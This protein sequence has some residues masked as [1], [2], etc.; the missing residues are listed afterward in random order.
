MRIYIDNLFQEGL[1]K[2]ITHPR[3]HELASSWAIVG[4]KTD[5][6]ADRARRLH[7]LLEIIEGSVPHEE[8]RYQDWL[9]FARRWSELNSL[10][11]DPDHPSGMNET[12]AR[13]EGVRDRMD[14]SFTAWLSDRYS[15][16]HNQPPVPPVML[17]HV[18]R[19]LARRMGERPEG[20]VALVLVDGLAL[21]QWVGV[22]EVLTEQRS[23]LR[24][25]EG[26]VFAWIPTL[27][28]VSRQACFAGR[29]PM[30]FQ[31]SIGSTSAEPNAWKRF[32]VDEGLSPAAAGFVKK[33][34]EPEDLAA[35][36]EILSRPNLRAFALVV[37]KVDQIMHGMVM[38]SVGM[39]TLVRQWAKQGMMA[40]LL[41]MLLDRG[42]SVF[43][44]SDHGN[45]ET[46]GYGRPQEGALVDT[47]GKRV[48][49]YSDPVLRDG[50]RRDFP[51]AIPWPLIGLPDGYHPLIAPGRRA[52]VR[53]G[54]SA[55]AH[56]GIALE[57]VIVPLVEIDRS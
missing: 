4:V 6:V 5:P 51:E 14:E 3:A 22:R 1:L 38:G 25:R 9:A 11:S 17:H 15:T 56:G 49:V 28:S 32:W 40:E 7:G 24:F 10:V 18:P 50:V 29:T 23:G 55:V 21:E 54:E 2:Q 27:T 37:D 47:H 20:K 19:L 34:R 44:T 42:F 16:L 45:V 57:E 52:F 35:V 31:S 30:Y 46:R 41:D 53:E 48:R 33:L 43:L 8:A 13:Y 39:Q 36:G 26:N 12:R